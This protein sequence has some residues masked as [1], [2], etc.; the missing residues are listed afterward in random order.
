MVNRRDLDLMGL[1][2]INEI[3]HIETQGSTKPQAALLT[4][5]IKD[6]HHGT[7]ISV[8]TQRNP[9]LPAEHQVRRDQADRVARVEEIALLPHLQM[10]LAKAILKMP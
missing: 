7:L 6:A 1:V 4:G 5:M 8:G 10:F 9:H 2:S 3:N